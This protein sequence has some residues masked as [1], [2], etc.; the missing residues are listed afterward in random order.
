V[1]RS[2][3]CP[4]ADFRQ[5]PI[6][7]SGHPF[8]HLVGFRN[9]RRRSLASQ[10]SCREVRGSR[11]GLTTDLVDLLESVSSAV[12]IFGTLVPP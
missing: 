8:N 10:L 2:G 12:R 7:T 4:S 5:A 11:D 9:D 6:S 1:T 3:H